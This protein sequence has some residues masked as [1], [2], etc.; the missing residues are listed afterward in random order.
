VLAFEEQNV[1]GRPKGADAFSRLLNYK[2]YQYEKAAA[3]KKD[4][5][6]NYYFIPHF[7]N[8][9]LSVVFLLYLQL[10]GILYTNV[11]TSISATFY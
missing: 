1:Q 5:I 9:M 4:K 8:T 11:Y 6:F 10:K 2:K 3:D 7:A